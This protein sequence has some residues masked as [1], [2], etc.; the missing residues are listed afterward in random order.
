MKCT[1]SDW[2]KAVRFTADNYRPEELG[3]LSPKEVGTERACLFCDMTGRIEAKT[4]KERV[5][6]CN[7]CI[8]GKLHQLQKGENNDPHKPPC[9]NQIVEAPKG[10]DTAARILRS[11][12]LLDKV[13]P[14]L[15]SID[16]T[17]A[18]FLQD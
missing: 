8:H 9:L 1:K 12:F 3:G 18:F 15:Q 11:A 14:L 16:A 2:V 5:A 4:G 17:D 6:C 10:N 13:I 7:D